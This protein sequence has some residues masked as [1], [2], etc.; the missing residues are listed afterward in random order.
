MTPWKR[1]AHRIITK[2]SLIA[3]QEAN[4]KGRG[5]HKPYS[6]PPMAASLGACRMAMPWDHSI[7][8]KKLMTTH[9]RSR[10]HDVNLERIPNHPNL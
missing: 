3:Y 10:S 7:R 5:K 9:K 2:L 6:V 8:L 1:K 4:P